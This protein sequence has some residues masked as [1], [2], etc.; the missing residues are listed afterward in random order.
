MASVAKPGSQTRSILALAD[1]NNSVRNCAL[2]VVTP[3][4]GCYSSHIPT[5][6]SPQYYCMYLDPASVVLVS[7]RRGPSVNSSRDI[8]DVLLQLSGL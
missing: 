3:F 4:E 8:A 5:L 6:Q 1:L 2:A 7:E